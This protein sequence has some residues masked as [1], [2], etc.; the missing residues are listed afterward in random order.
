MENAPDVVAI[1]GI[2]CRLPGG[3]DSPAGLVEFLKRHGDGIVAVPPD[4]WSIDRFVSD[5]PNTPGRAY[6]SHAGFLQKSVFDFDIAPFGLSP[7]EVEYLDPQ[8]RLLLEA[9]YDAVEDAG[10]RLGALRGSNTGVYVGAFNVD[11][12]DVV[13]LPS[14]RHLMSAHTA[15]GTSHTVLSNR[16]SYT[17]DFHG[18]SFTVD[19]ACSS[20]L[21]TVHYACRDLLDG[22]TD[23]ALAGGVNVML[24]PVSTAIMCKGHFLAP[25]GRSK[26]FDAAADGYGRGEGVGL[27]V[28]KRLS[29]AL[30]D[31]DRIYAVILASGVN[32]D[33]RT[34]GMPM[35]NGAAQTDLCR[36]VVKRANIDPSKV[37]F[38][39]A[40]GTGTRAGDPIEV[41][42]LAS[43]YCGDGRETPLCVGS[44]KTNVGHLEAAAGVTGLIKA[45]LSLH[46]ECIF[47]LRHL[48]SLNPDIPFDDL[49]VRVPLEVEAWPAGA[50]RTVAVNSFGYGGTNA[51]AVLGTAAGLPLA[52]PCETG[53]APRVALVTAFDDGALR[54]RAAQLLST[55]SEALPGAL[56]ALSHDGEQLP[57]RAFAWGDDE[58]NL[59]ETLAALAEGQPHKR[60]VLG[61]ARPPEKTLFVYTGMGPQWPLMGRRLFA[62][63]TVFREAA[64]EVDRHFR[65]VSGWS[66]LDELLCDEA[67]SRMQR[68]FVAQP[69]N[70]LLQVCL[71]RLLEHHG[72]RADGFLGHSVGELTAAWAS[73]CLSLSAASALAYHRSDLQQKVAGK[74]TMAAL[75]IS[76][77]EADFLVRRHGNLSVAAINGPSSIALAGGRAELEAVVALVE[78]QGRFARM[79][80]VEVAYHS[81]HMDP[82]EGAFFDRLE[83][84][85]FSAPDKPLYSTARGERLRD[86]T[87]DARYWWE[88]A[89]RPVL[90]ARALKAALADGYGCALEIGPHPVLAEALTN[91]A[92]AEERSLLLAHTQRRGVDAVDAFNACL[93]TLYTA[94]ADVD[95]NTLVPRTTSVR[96]PYPFQRKR[97]WFEPEANQSYRLGRPGAHPLLDQK[98]EASALSFQVELAGRRFAWIS[99][100]CV[101]GAVVFPGAGYIEAAI[102]LSAEAWGNDVEHVIENV[103]L[104]NPLV[105]TDEAP[106][107]LHVELR[108]TE[109]CVSSVAE[110]GSTR[111]ARARISG[112]S[113]YSA[114]PPLAAT[115]E[116]ESH[117]IAE[118][119][120]SFA[121]RGLAYGASFRMLES[122]TSGGNRV[123]ARLS[124]PEGQEGYWL[125]PGT[126]DSA[127]QALLSIL[128]K[129]IQG[130]V[131]P[132]SVGCVRC[133]RKAGPGQLTMVGEARLSGTDFVAD[134]VL[135]DAA[136]V[137]T[138]AVRD[139]VCKPVDRTEGATARPEWLYEKT[140]KRLDA[141]TE[142]RSGAAFLVVGEGGSEL[143]TSLQ[144]TGAEVLQDLEASRDAAVH[145][146]FVPG[147]FDA[148]ESEEHLLHLGQLFAMTARRPNTRVTLITQGAFAIEDNE[149]VNPA[150]TALVGLARVAMTEYPGL[151]VRVIDVGERALPEAA[152]RQLLGGDW[153]EEECALRES[154]L[155]G[156]RIGRAERLNTARRAELAAP[157]TGEMFE[158]VSER[159]GRLDS[160]RYRP[161]L[162]DNELRADEVQVQIDAASLNFKDV[163]KALGMLDDIALE[164][165][166]LGKQLGLDASGTVT[167]VGSAVTDIAVGD[168]VFVFAP[169]ALASHVRVDQRFVVRAARGHTSTDACTYGVFQTVW[170]GLYERA[171]LRAGERVLIHS[172]AGGVGLAAIQL[173]RHVG[174]EV[175]ATAGT[176]EKREFLRRM[177]I[178]HVYDSRTLDFSREVLQDTDGVG[179]DVVLNSLAGEAVLHNI[180]VL[181]PGGRFVELGKQD[182]SKSLQ[183]SM[184]PFNRAISLIAI[185]MDRMATEKPSYFKPVAEAVCRAFDE[186]IFQPLV[187][188]SYPA[189]RVVDAFRDLASGGHIGKIV[190]DFSGGVPELAR[191]LTPKPLFRRNRSYLVVGGLGGFGLRTAQWMVENGARHLTLA[192]RRGRA[193]AQGEETLRELARESGATIECRALDVTSEADVRSLVRELSERPEPLAGVFHSAMVLED[194]PLEL[195]DARSL[196]AVMGPKARGAYNLHLATRDSNLDHFVLYSSVSA[197]VGNPGQGAYAA[198][199]AFLDGLA[200]H[201]RSLGLPATAIQWGALAEVGVVS[202]EAHVDAHLRSIGL[203][204]LTP[205]QGLTEL[206]VALGEDVTE[207]GI[208]DIDWMRWMRTTPETRWNRLE[209]L[210]DTEDQK[211]GRQSELLGRLRALSADER[212]SFVLQTTC[213]SIAPIFK[214]A[215]AD[216]DAQRTLKDYGLDSLMALEVQVALEEN[217]GVELSTMELL[218]GRSIVALSLVVLKRLLDAAPEASE[219]GA[220][221]SGSPPSLASS[222]RKTAPTEDGLVEHLLERICVQR[223]YFALESIRREGDF[224]TALVHPVAPLTA[225]ASAVALAEAARHASILGSCA[226]RLADERDGRIYYPVRGA[227]LVRASSKSLTPASTVSVRAKLLHQDPKAS[228][229]VVEAS[230][231]STEGDELSCFETTL[232]VIPEGDFQSLF[233]SHH[234]KTD[235]PGLRDPY[236]EWQA[237]PSFTLAN[238]AA[239]LEL[240]PVLSDHCLGHFVD[241]PAYPVSIMARDATRVLTECVRQRRN[242]SD[243]RVQV[244]GG[245]AKTSRFA[246]AGESLALD[247]RRVEGEGNHEV[248][249]MSFSADGEPCAWFQMHVRILE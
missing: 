87:H 233:A 151:D 202:R 67:T 230:L 206:G 131:V 158:L 54:A 83:T 125:F 13:S 48:G 81:H 239:R 79:M 63:N 227:R 240:G 246:F 58:A 129:H 11:L 141:P 198:A 157:A 17:F 10:L 144:D 41:A 94:G 185:D 154:G 5:D 126:L 14:N 162:L 170:H 168:R 237:L 145:V 217:V 124:V 234:R 163:M 179:V 119:Y 164:R 213:E 107:T 200:A 7:R 53:P 19:T 56:S 4:R 132:V 194:A 12:R 180:R 96:L 47:P 52:K 166:Y 135:Y 138:F 236:R 248:W 24:S 214:L 231:W 191:G 8:Q 229:A 139:L 70:F 221:V 26:A 29:D 244:V 176:E 114:L 28:L 62:T 34:D 73:G 155:F 61:K 42:A 49:R 187:S 108:G 121:R 86:A 127:F 60:V 215:A 249:R 167:A 137:P 143:C 188:V 36:A 110:H 142:L 22:L 160:L 46:E 85:E 1:V 101:Q 243:V 97:Y 190:I 111:H 235:D 147:P 172:A 241:Y 23:L 117:D 146:A 75:A 71:T 152:L 156:L 130:A 161:R 91:A 92:R 208:I 199:N 159:P 173:A 169:G 93:G 105:L 223:P 2:G 64:A 212:E 242:L 133:L 211:A 122:V 128:P 184:L 204:P 134:F 40:H 219:P 66:I 195:L 225:E 55:S 32:Q 30:R 192:S 35:P 181:S 18:P 226:A 84:L 209:V 6:V 182:I 216:I 183:L 112:K 15:T 21:V 116:G 99:D 177:G 247:A 38:V 68:N 88:N 90:L 65:A 43:V 210:R 103:E 174:A 245:E 196:A 189:A 51:H 33:G 39:E 153:S 205:E 232:H 37:A 98:D 222:M 44:V 50:D 57:S 78:A 45:A 120:T 9:S 74:G 197:I 106:K 100:H 77:E 76:P 171:Q 238:D 72:V 175:F 201:R 203:T 186:G 31:G 109:L 20:S 16:I 25:D 3:V 95:M 69:A 220:P 148:S 115:A 178:D 27:V 218:A 150:H 118:L 123:V 59:R 207:R 193:D 136:G 224:L 89:R 228:T 113:R 140:W 104:E 102:A 165:T 149:T 80:H 82:L